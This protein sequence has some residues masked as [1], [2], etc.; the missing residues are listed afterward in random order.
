MHIQRGNALT[1]FRIILAL[2]LTAMVALI[3]LYWDAD[4]LGPPADLEQASRILNESQQIAGAIEIYQ[5]AGQGMPE[6]LPDITP[7]YLTRIP[8]GAAM[9]SY[10]QSTLV[11]NPDSEK[12]CQRLNVFAGIAESMREPVPSC[13]AID[14]EI[15]DGIVDTEYFCCDDSQ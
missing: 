12:V 10:D 3:A 15:Q 6:T 9:W 1:P 11:M 7:D 14:S 13:R 5:G 4:L 2:T 8:G